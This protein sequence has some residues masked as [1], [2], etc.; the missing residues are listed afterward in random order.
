[1]GNVMIRDKKAFT[2]IELIVVVA[3]IGILATIIIVS[4]LGTQKRSRDSKRKG[5]LQA[6]AGSLELYKADH[7][8][9]PFGSG[10]LGT[11]ERSPVNLRLVLKT[12]PPVG[13]CDYTV[14]TTVDDSKRNLYCLVTEGFLSQYP[15]DPNSSY[16]YWYMGNENKSAYKIISEYRTGN[17]SYESSPTGDVASTCRSSAGDYGDLSDASGSGATPAACKRFAAWSSNISAKYYP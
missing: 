11:D 2:T 1:M 8:N 3:I 5:D 16:V 15:E 14:S 13:G 7:K 12:S 9:Y 6:I 10:T 17:D 4:Y